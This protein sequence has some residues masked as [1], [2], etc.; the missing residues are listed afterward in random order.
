MAKATHNGTCQLCGNLQAVNAKTGRLAKHGYTVEFGYFSG[1]CAGS[2][3]LPLE[4]SRDL[5]DRV[6]EDWTIEA[7]KMKAYTADQVT[8]VVARDRLTGKQKAVDLED[9]R[10]TVAAKWPARRAEELVEGA[11]NERVRQLHRMGA[12]LENH[13]SAMLKHADQVAGEDLKPRALD[14]ERERIEVRN[15]SARELGAKAAELKA[16][17]W[18]VRVFWQKRYLTATRAK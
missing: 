2:N 17:G 12:G 14:S 8:K 7:E 18:T 4:I 13:I 15:E 1:S 3:E 16:D 5:L 10:A 11:I 9:Y 6:V